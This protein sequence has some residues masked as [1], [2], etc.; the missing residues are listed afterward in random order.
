MAVTLLFFRKCFR[1]YASYMMTYKSTFQ[2]KV[3]RPR[4]FIFSIF[5]PTLFIIFY[6]FNYFNSNV[7]LTERIDNSIFDI[8]LCVILISLFAIIFLLLLKTLSRSFE[9]L[10]L[11]KVQKL[12]RNYTSDFTSY[13]SVEKMRQI[14][15]GLTRYDFLWFE[16]LN[17][18]SEIRNRFVEIFT[19]GNFPSEPLFQLKMDNLQ[20]YVLFEYLAKETKDLSLT[21]FMKIV[22]NKNAKATVDSITESYRK[23]VPENIKNR[24]LIELIFVH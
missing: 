23:C 4:I 8:F 6:S 20:T 18:Q 19:T 17:E 10:Y 9:R 13:A 15:D 12:V 11:S 3:D 22:K 5:L 24:N 14:F 21:G 1:W 16:D 2:A 7:A